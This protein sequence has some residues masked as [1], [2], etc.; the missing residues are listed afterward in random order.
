MR[1]FLTFLIKGLKKRNIF[2]YW[3]QIWKA[4]STTTSKETNKFTKD[5]VIFIINIEIAEEK[6]PTPKDPPKEYIVKLTEPSQISIEYES[7][8]SAPF[9]KLIDNESK[10]FVNELKEFSQ[11]RINGLESAYSKL[12]KNV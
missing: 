3:N 8:N 6:I 12:Q 2:N 7:K 1:V 11:N 10:A 5:N 4:P 9:A